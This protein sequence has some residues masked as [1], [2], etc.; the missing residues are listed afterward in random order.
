MYH[1]MSKRSSDHHVR[2]CHNPLLHLAI[3]ASMKLLMNH[4]VKY[5]TINIMC[6]SITIFLDTLV[7]SSKLVV[8]YCYDE[9]VICMSYG[10]LTLLQ[11]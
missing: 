5:V 8:T 10:N 1:V 3:D 4:C 2:F 6:R 9:G 7:I 11:I